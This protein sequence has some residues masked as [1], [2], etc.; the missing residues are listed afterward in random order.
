MVV[1]EH[2][3]RPKENVDNSPKYLIRVELRFTDD[4]MDNFPAFPG[5]LR[6]RYQGLELRERQ[7]EERQALK[8]T[9]MTVQLYKQ[10]FE[11]LCYQ[12]ELLRT[13]WGD[14]FYKG[15]V[16]AIKHRLSLSPF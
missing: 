13:V 14:E 8:Q 7:V 3:E 11:K 16:P 1:V 5:R 4:I 6:S 9:N 10:R 15:L 2:L 12:T